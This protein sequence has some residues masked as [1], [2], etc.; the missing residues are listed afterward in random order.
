MLFSFVPKHENIDKQAFYESL[1]TVLVSASHYCD[2]STSLSLSP[3]KEQ[4]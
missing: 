1:S 2:F 3:P 4:K